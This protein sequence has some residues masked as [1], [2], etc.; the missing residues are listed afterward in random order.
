M[1]A[2]PRG[3]AFRVEWRQEA[4]Q[5]F[6]LVPVD[7]AEQSFLAFR[8]WDEPALQSLP[9]QRLTLL[10]D[11]YRRVMIVLLIFVATALVSLWSALR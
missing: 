6:M 3:D 11:P 4:Q 9:W 8:R 10:N 2:T 7:Q 1:Q 5:R